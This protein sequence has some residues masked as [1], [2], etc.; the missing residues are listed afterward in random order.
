MVRSPPVMNLPIR[1]ATDR[2]FTGLTM[3][4]SFVPTDA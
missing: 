1:G 2:A 3:I 4:A